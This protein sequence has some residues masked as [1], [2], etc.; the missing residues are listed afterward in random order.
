MALDGTSSLDH[1]RPAASTAGPGSI[2]RIIGGALRTRRGRL[3][4]LL[5][6][7]VFLIAYGGPLAP[8]QH[9][10]DLNSTPFA[11]PGDAA[12]LL[13]ADVL[14]RDVVARILGGGWLLLTMAILATA[15]G[16]T[17]GTIIGVSAAYWRGWTDAV[18]MRSVDILLAIPALVFIL[19]TLSL[20]GPQPWLVIFVVGFIQA[21]QVARVVHAASQDLCERDF[22]KAVAMLGVPS[23]DVIR[24]QILPML[25]TPLMV[26]TGLRLSY[27]I[28][29]IAGLSFLGLGTP[30][31][32]PDWGVMINENRLGMA[33]NVWGVAAPALIVALLAIGTNTF[34]DAIA[35]ANLG[36]QGAEELLV[37]SALAVT[38][39]TEVAGS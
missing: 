20:L 16:V 5:T 38:S 34:A 14:G 9:P 29:L 10:L 6:L 26:E 25:I 35:R 1:G 31:P 17:L 33:S 36:D 37:A 13:G 19:M 11:P 30:P 21:P 7:A 18:L 3:S 4:A 39:A 12:G 2:A 32:N 27:S 8:G 24:R 23:R 15:F 28:V 22:V